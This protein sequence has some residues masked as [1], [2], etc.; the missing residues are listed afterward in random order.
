MNKLVLLRGRVRGKV[1]NSFVV[2][3]YFSMASKSLNLTQVVFF[4]SSDFASI[5]CLGIGNRRNG[6]GVRT[7]TD[8]GFVRAPTPAEGEREREREREFEL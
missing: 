4:K 5:V 1:R 3:N 6:S 8:I 7:T 2:R